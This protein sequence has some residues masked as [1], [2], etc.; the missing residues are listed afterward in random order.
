MFMIF[1]SSGERSA[2][3]SAL[4]CSRAARSRCVTPP[5]LFYGI[6]LPLLFI[7]TVT[8]LVSVFLRHDWTRDKSLFTHITEGNIRIVTSKS[9]RRANNTEQGS[10]GEQSAFK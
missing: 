3:D 9:R 6:Y 7:F 4:P 1:L 10:T 2:N 5:E 8:V